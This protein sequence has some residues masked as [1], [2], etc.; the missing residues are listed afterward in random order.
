DSVGLLDVQSGAVRELPAGV[1]H[2]ALPLGDGR[3]LLFGNSAVSGEASLQI[4]PMGDLNQR[5]TIVDL[6]ALSPDRPLFVEQAVLV[7]PNTVRVFGTTFDVDSGQ[8]LGFSC[9]VDVAAKA[10]TNSAV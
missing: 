10:V 9:T 1:H 2:D 6:N 7:A 5:E 8:P 4:A 3:L